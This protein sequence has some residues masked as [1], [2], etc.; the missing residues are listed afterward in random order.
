VKINYGRKP[1]RLTFLETFLVLDDKP[2]KSWKVNNCST[3]AD[4]N[5]DYVNLK[6]SHCCHIYNC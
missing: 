6:Y 5:S 3:S 4:K 2:S 1:K